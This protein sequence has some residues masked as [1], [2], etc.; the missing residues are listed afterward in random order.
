MIAFFQNRS[1]TEHSED[2]PIPIKSDKNIIAYI[3]LVHFFIN[4]KTQMN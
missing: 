3:C 4:V 2:R 1:D